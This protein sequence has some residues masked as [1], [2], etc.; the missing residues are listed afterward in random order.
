MSETNLMSYEKTVWYQQ[1]ASE[2]ARLLSVDPAQ[3][4]SD[5]EAAER[6]QQ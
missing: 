3:G 1:E 5:T 2:V 6:L 4:L